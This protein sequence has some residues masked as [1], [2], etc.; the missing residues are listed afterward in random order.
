MSTNE[1]QDGMIHR[2][3]TRKPVDDR[4]DREL[5]A[6]LAKYTAVEPR[7]GLE[8]RILANLRAER[9]HVR[10]WLWPGVAAFA[11][12]IIV[13]ALSL[14][15]NSG[16]RPNRE[17]RHASP[18]VQD[19][20]HNATQA[21][22]KSGSNHLRPTQAAAI[23][24]TTTHTAPRSLA[25]A[26]AAPHMEQFPSPQPLS[27]QEQ[28]LASYV[29]TFQDDATL[30]ARARMESLRQDVIEEANEASLERETRN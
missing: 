12:V 26:A 5:D 13:V 30:V 4:F 18:A 11:A 24:K 21:A 17:A 15:W 27:E 9:E 25:V 7:A 23:K 28:I 1:R 8:D 14:V 10:G 20:A 16:P 19:N 29:S 2:D 6:V 3:V 22:S